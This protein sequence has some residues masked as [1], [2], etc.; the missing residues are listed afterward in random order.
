MCGL[1]FRSTNAPSCMSIYPP[2]P[3]HTST[4]SPRTRVRLARAKPFWF[5][6][7][8]L[9]TPSPNGLMGPTT[10]KP[11]DIHVKRLKRARGRR[12]ALAI[13]GTVNGGAD[14]FTAPGE[15]NRSYLF[16]ALMLRSVTYNRVTP[17]T[18]VDAVFEEGEDPWK[19]AILIRFAQSL[20]W[21]S[22]PVV[23]LVL[24][25]FDEKA[26]CPN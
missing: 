14:I 3:P 1:N 8:Q 9:V 2:F 15:T 13:S 26:S 16:S 6:M 19:G 11:E 18:H 25:D 22:D 10:N 20:K 21:S 4:R 24:D 7:I 12:R 5:P 17:S 23:E